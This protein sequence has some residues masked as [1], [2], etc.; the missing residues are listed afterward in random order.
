[1]VILGLRDHEVVGTVDTAT[2][3]V[4]GELARVER[5]PE[6]VDIG[7]ASSGHLRTSPYQIWGGGVSQSEA[8][9]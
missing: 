6:A 1:M 7:T 5:L 9:E 3:T 8:T 4:S 2:E